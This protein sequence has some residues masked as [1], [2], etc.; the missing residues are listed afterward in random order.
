MES[1][2]FKYAIE[3]LESIV[4]DHPDFWA[5]Y[6]NLAL[7]YFSMGK[8]KS[9][10]TSSRCIKQNKGNL[11]AFC[12]LA[13][14]YYYEKK[15]EELESLLKLLMKIKPYL[16]EHRYKLGAT[17]ALVGRHK[18]AFNW[19]RSIQKRGFDGDAGYYFWLSHSAYFT[20]HE[21]IAHEA[22]SDHFQLAVVHRQALRRRERLVVAGGVPDVGVPGQHPVVVI[23][24]LLGDDVVHRILVAQRLVH[25]PRV[26]PGVGRREL[27]PG[28]HAV[29]Q[30][31]GHVLWV[32]HNRMPCQQGTAN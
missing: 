28:G 13:V 7:A 22:Y 21:A 6:N 12:N 17:F 23:G 11:H 18:E 2:D 5:A 19:L 30:S 1:G 15:E 14:F 20:G 16:I 24:V 32:R 27:E 25:R 4:S 10:C 8:R 3:L 9:K 29:R 26:G 31:G